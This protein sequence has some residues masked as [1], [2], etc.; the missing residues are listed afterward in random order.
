MSL[1]MKKIIWCLGLVM[2]SSCQEE[3]Y[4]N[5]TKD[6]LTKQAVFLNT[7]EPTIKFSLKENESKE[8]TVDIR[9]VI[10][11]SSES[12]ITVMTADK[13]QLE[14]YNSKYNTEYTVL[15]ASMYNVSKQVTM[16]KG[17]LVGKITLN[18]NQ[19]NFS[20]KEAYALPIKISSTSP[21]SVSGRDSAILIIEKELEPIVT[22]V[23]RFGGYE[24][25]ISNAFGADDIPVAQWTLEATVNRSAYNRN[26]RSIAG[27]KTADGNPKNEIFTRFGDV[28][29]DPNQLQIKTGAAQ[30]DVPKEKLAAKPNEWYSL[31]FTYDGKTT[32]VFVNGEEVVSREIRDGIYTLN[33]LWIGGANELVREVRFWKRAVPAKELKENYWKVL[34]PKKAEG[35]LFYYPMNGKKY[36][37]ET[38]EITEDESKIWD[39]SSSKAHL[40][41]PNNSNFDDNKG[42]NYIFYPPKK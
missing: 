15:P 35:L 4:E 25:G 8:V 21:T 9:S 3:L 40:T 17:E 31:A 24:A 5:E 22:K 20:D 14:Q 34:D 13:T 32:R 30:I 39:W 27:T 23:Y 16:K 11:V 38:G 18:V 2:I 26:N 33:G 41:K 28:T 7:N 1:H 10:P 36:D 12:H 37:H 6:H 19:I 29:I 42:K